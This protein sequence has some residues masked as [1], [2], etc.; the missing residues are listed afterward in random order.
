MSV[1]ALSW[2]LKLQIK[3]ASAK[4]VLICLSDFTT[5]RGKSYPSMDTIKRETSLTE[6][7]VEYGLQALIDLKVITDTGLRVGD[8]KEI[9]VF[10]LMQIKELP[11]LTGR[12]KPTNPDLIKADEIYKLYPRPVAKP[13]S[14]A[15]ITK[16]INDFGFD[17]VK[18]RTILFAAAWKGRTDLEHCPH[19]ATWFHQHRFND[20]PAT[21]GAVT[22]AAKTKLIREQ[23]M[24]TMKEVTD[25]ADEKYPDLKER[26]GYAASFY[27]HWN[28]SSRWWKIDG[29][30][31]DWKLRFSDQVAKWREEAAAK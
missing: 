3:P 30:I 17:H 27:R 23:G 26:Y 14:L 20:D 2:A 21:W 11:K 7:Q 24:P 19:S 8:A 1:Q 16:A 9:R 5:D 12:R 29:K 22:P 15:K 28:S 10:Q 4:S 6:A 18:E 31:I 13:Q 25:Y